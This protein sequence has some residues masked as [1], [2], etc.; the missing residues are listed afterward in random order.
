MTFTYSVCIGGAGIDYCSVTGILYTYS[1]FITL[2]FYA[3]GLGLR[4]PSSWARLAQVSATRQRYRCHRFG[5]LLRWGFRFLSRIRLRCFD[6][7]RF[8][9][10]RV[11]LPF[12]PTSLRSL[13]ILASLR[14]THCDS[15]LLAYPH[16]FLP[17]GTFLVCRLLSVGQG[18]SCVGVDRH[19]DYSADSSPSLAQYGFVGGFL[20]NFA[21]FA[22]V[23]VLLGKFNFSSFTF[24]WRFQCLSLPTQP[25]YSP[26]SLSSSVA[27]SKQCQSAFSGCPFLVSVLA[28]GVRAAAHLLWCFLFSL[29]YCAL[30]L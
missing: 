24:F 25:A 2:R 12:Y 11:L 14:V 15:L 16:V 9:R 7:S 6:Y 21:I 26:L 23:S 27:V 20:P 8:T 10:V 1:V 5:T 30:L 17:C 13:R 18:Y 4:W 3:S 29:L 28:L 19:V 22:L